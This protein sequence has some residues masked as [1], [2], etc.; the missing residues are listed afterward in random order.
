MKEAE[1]GGAKADAQ[2]RT[3]A[4]RFKWPTFGRAAAERAA[5]AAEEA[6]RVAAEVE[7]AKTMQAERGGSRHGSSSSEPGYSEEDADSDEA[8]ADADETSLSWNG[9][10]IIFACALNGIFGDLCYSMLATFLPG[11]AL[12][13]GI[14]QGVVGWIFSAQPLGTF[15]GSFI[16]PIVLQQSW[17]DAYSLLRRAALLN[18][19]VNVLMGITA[20]V[21]ALSDTPWAFGLWLSSLRIFQGACPRLAHASPPA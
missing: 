6:E 20:S 9:I 2:E 16:V 7:A 1:E 21:P 18:A 12:R 13:R 10:F 15:A 17:A 5:A 19:I 14:D 4:F 3:P 8:R 11:E